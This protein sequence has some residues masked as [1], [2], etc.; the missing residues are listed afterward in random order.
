L[1]LNFPNWNRDCWLFVEIG[2]SDG[3]RCPLSVVL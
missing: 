3:T 1:R 2:I